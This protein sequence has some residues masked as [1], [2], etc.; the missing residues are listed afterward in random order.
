MPATCARIQRNTR[1]NPAR[2]FMGRRY[3]SQPQVLPRPGVEWADR[4]VRPACR[5]P[6]S[7][8]SKWEIEDY[9]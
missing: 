7:G 4:I 8:K 6:E 3:D 2:I 9:A 5:R 1:V